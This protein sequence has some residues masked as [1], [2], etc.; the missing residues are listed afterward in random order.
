MWEGGFGV[1]LKGAYSISYTSPL[2]WAS[3]GGGGT[4]KL[5]GGGGGVGG[6]EL[7]YERGR[8]CSSSRLG[9][10]KLRILVP[11]SVFW[12]KRRYIKP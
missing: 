3:G 7:L 6:G 8:E 2:W 11:L 5:R 4:P 12:T 1:L 10:C 9:V